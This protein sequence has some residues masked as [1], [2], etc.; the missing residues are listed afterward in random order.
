MMTD[1]KVKAGFQW[2]VDESERQPAW[3]AEQ[4]A[5]ASVPFGVI[6]C[7]LVQPDNGDWIGVA[8]IFLAGALAII[9]TRVKALFSM[10]GSA[11]FGRALIWVGLLVRLSLFVANPAGW[12]VAFIINESLLLS[13]LYFAACKPPRP[14][15]R[16]QAV[17]HGAA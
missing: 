8:I 17:A 12:K 15:R 3:W 7:V 9:A 4:V 2:L 10:L 5:W 14:R 13:F 16:R 11:G 1:Q 6:A